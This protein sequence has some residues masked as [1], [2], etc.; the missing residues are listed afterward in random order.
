MGTRA[1][2][3]PLLAIISD[4][5]I[6][7]QR[8]LRIGL[9]ISIG[10]SLT[11]C[12]APSRPQAVVPP[13]PSSGPSAQVKV[14]P[15]D[16]ERIGRKIWQNESAGSISGLTA[17]NKNEAFAS[18]GIGHFIWYP[19]GGRQTYEESF[20]P[21]LGFLQA[22][23][24]RLPAG[25]TP[26]SPCPWNSRSAFQASSQS[27][28]MKAIRQM[29]SQTVG[30]Q[31]EFIINRMQGALPKMLRAAPPSDRQRIKDQ[32]YAMTET[33][34]GLYALIDYVNFKGEGVNPKERYKG[35]GWGMLQ[36]LQGMQG[37]PKGQAAA[38]EFAASAKRTLGRRIANAPKKESQWRAGWFKRCDTYA[39]PL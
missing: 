10:L 14:A 34:N 1:L 29:L 18:M 8:H 26:A 32:F 27:P 22:R 17:W 2:L 25:L 21:L 6:I 11:Q 24:V 30:L 37:T 28:K 23:G 12:A 38:R 16:A 13:P 19:A 4:T 3:Y 15:R 35:Q 36:V 9:L 5:M 7:N 33:S 39:R 20:R 31:T